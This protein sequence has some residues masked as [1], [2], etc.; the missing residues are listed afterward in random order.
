[1]F[2]DWQMFWFNLGKEPHIAIT[3]KGAKNEAE[4]NFWANFFGYSIKKPKNRKKR[5]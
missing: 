3:L 4:F 2:C 1:M 5:K